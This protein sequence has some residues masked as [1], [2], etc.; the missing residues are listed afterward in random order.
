MYKMKAPGNQ[1]NT[2]GPTIEKTSVVTRT[3]V[4][5]KKT[6]LQMS[7]EVFY[8]GNL[9][10]VVISGIHGPGQDTHVAIQYTGDKSTVDT[11]ISRVEKMKESLND[12]PVP[13]KRRDQEKEEMKEMLKTATAALVLLA[14]KTV[15]EKEKE[16][17]RLSETLD[18]EMVEEGK[19]E[20]EEE[21][22]G[23]GPSSNM[24]E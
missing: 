10:K 3:T 24:P 21:E 2:Y 9:K 17:K 6:Q 19:E 5:S 14:G 13:K 4:C 11:R 23:P 22:E 15:E 12:E 7:A 18:R 20:E 16:M 8:L 1:A